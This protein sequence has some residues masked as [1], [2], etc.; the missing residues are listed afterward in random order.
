MSLL[1]TKQFDIILV[2]LVVIVVGAL[3]WEV[4]H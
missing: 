3:V 1:S 4:L 2:S